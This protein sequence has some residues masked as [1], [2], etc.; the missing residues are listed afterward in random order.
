MGAASVPFSPCPRFPLSCVCSRDDARGLQRV[1]PLAI[2]GAPAAAFG[3]LK[4]LVAELPR[5]VIVTATDT[6]LHA[7]CRS[8]R[9]YVDELELCLCPSGRVVHVRSASRIGLIWD[10]GTN[11]AR[12]ELLRQR[13]AGAPGG[14]P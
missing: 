7:E 6:Y 14:E 5:T 10:M 13:F 12:V 2:T 1:E 4:N 3:R 11:R 9:G 8:P